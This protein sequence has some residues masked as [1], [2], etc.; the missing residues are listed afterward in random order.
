MIAWF[1]MTPETDES[2]VTRNTTEVDA[3]MFIVPPDVPFAPVP[4]R[5]RTVREA[6]M[7]SP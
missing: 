4:S 7:Y 3:P 2:T 6:E 1:W 5:T